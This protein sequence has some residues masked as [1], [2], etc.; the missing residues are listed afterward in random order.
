WVIDSV[1]HTLDDALMN[2]QQQISSRL[3]FGHLRVIVISEDVAKKGLQNVNDYLR[4]DSE[5]RR[6]AW[7]MISKGNAMEVMEA[8]PELER[9]PS[10]YLMSTLD[11]AVEL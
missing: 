10:L 5:V 3:F 7:M 9:V 4:R 2:L 11:Y 6:M 8:A 1:G